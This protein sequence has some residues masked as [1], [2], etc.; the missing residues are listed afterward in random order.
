MSLTRILMR[1]TPLIF[2]D[3]RLPRQRPAV[4]VLGLMWYPFCSIPVLAVDT[5]TGHL[6]L[7][8]KWML[9]MDREPLW[10]IG[11]REWVSLPGLG[12]D[13]IKAKID[14]GAATSSLHAFDLHRFRR[15]GQR[16]VR[17]AVHPYQRSRKAVVPAEAQILED[18]RVRSSNGIVELRP[19]VQMD[20][21]ILDRTWTI[22]VTLTNRDE[23][24]FRMLLGRRAI[25]KRFLIDPD[26]SFLAGQ[27]DNRRQQ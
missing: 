21:R 17:F 5:S 3:L 18:R 23:M 22:D 4:V 25:R 19:V 14:T 2:R 26:R 13:A 24:G 11:W 8:Y 16:F 12:I 15:G 1:T 10:V 6:E 27:P 7:L 9:P 20:V